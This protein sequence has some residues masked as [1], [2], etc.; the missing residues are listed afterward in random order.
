[1]WARL[2][3]AWPGLLASKRPAACFLMIKAAGKPAAFFIAVKANAAEQSGRRIGS[4]ARRG[5]WRGPLALLPERNLRSVG[6][7]RGVLSGG[8]RSLRDLHHRLIS[9]EPPA[10]P[11]GGCHRRL[12]HGIMKPLCRPLQVCVQWRRKKA[13]RSASNAHG[14]NNMRT[15][16]LWTPDEGP[17]S[18][19]ATRRPERIVTSLP[20]FSGG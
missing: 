10:R 11:E 15:P 8:S 14:S 1:M 18:F 13:C 5:G 9:F 20:S 4:D 2:L 17:G 19:V 12:R 3:M 7:C 16:S 6:L